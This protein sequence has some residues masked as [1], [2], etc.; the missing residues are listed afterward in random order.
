MTFSKH[1]QIASERFYIFLTHIFHQA[2]RIRIWQNGLFRA[3][4][5]GWC[6]PCH[7]DL[8]V[9][10]KRHKIVVLI[11]INHI[12]M[13][14]FPA[15]KKKTTTLTQLSQCVKY[16]SF[17]HRIHHAQL[18]QMVE[19][20]ACK[21]D[22]FVPWWFEPQECRTLIFFRPSNFLTF[23]LGFSSPSFALI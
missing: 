17:Q 3:P 8:N 15:L 13:P 14:R 22:I 4:R 20:Q 16:S 9:S 11:K 10:D 6:F 21:L 19:N 5:I 7:H 12:V 18:A 23:G 1:Q 2:G